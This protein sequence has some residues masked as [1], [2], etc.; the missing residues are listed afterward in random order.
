V[1]GTKFLKPSPGNESKDTLLFT[2]GVNLTN[3]RKSLR[4]YNHLIV[5]NYI[6]DFATESMPE[7]RTLWVG[8][9]LVGVI[10]TIKEGVEIEK[11]NTKLAKFK[12]TESLRLIK[13]LERVFNYKSVVIRI[14]WGSSFIN[15][16]ETFPSIY[17]DLIPNIVEK[18]G[19]HIVRII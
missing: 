18:I 17:P 6:P 10:R 19:D 11:P 14:D 4:K 15:E 5:Q 7:E 12:R 9:K 8:Y 3:Y 13:T 2:P 1:K 16:F